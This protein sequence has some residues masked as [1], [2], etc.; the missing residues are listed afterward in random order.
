MALGGYDGSIR[1]DTKLNTKS[2]EASL[3]RLGGS[4]KK[5]SAAMGVAFGVTALIRL[6]KE[7]INVASDLEEVEN[8]VNVAFGSMKGK[9]EDFADTALEKF[10]MF[11][12][13]AKKTASTYMAMNKGMGLDGEKAADMAIAAAGRTGDIASFYNMKQ[14]EAD[15]LMKSIWT[16]E[17]ESLK[18]IGVVMTEVNL[19]QF[20]YQ[21]GINKTLSS[22]N[23]QE[24][25]MLRYQYV[26]EQTAL[27]QGDFER[28][29]DSWANQTRI[30]SGQLNTLKGILGQ[31]LIQALTPAVKMI[32]Q[33]TASLIKLAK[34]FSA[35]TAKL[36]GKQSVSQGASETSNGFESMASGADDYGKSIEK[37]KK[38]QDG[39]L[40]GIDEINN[41]PSPEDTAVSA[42]GALDTTGLEITPVDV[43]VEIGDNITI[44][45]KLEEIINKLKSIDLSP[46]KESLDNFFESVKKFSKPV[47]EGLEWFFD[48]VL[49]PLSKWTIE[50]AIPAFLDLLSA[51]LSVL[52]PILEAGQSVLQWL[53]EK[54]LQPIAEWTGEKIIEGLQWLTEKLEKLGGWL[55]EHQTALED[56]ILVLGSFAAVAAIVSGVVK[57]LDSGLT[58]AKIGGELAT[59]AVKGF[60]GALEFLCN[61]A[62][63]AV[64]AIGALVAIVVLLIKHW[65]EVKEVASKCW[66]WIVSVWEKAGDWFDKNVVEPLS[67]IW[68]KI[69]AVFAPAVEWFKLLFDNIWKTVSDVFYNIGVIASGCWEVIKAAWNIA[70]EWFRT[71]VIE[72]VSNFFS[73]MWDGLKTRAKEAWEGVKAAFSPVVDW[74]RNQFTAAWTAVK[75]VFSVGGKIFDGITQ[76]ITAAFKSVVNAIINGINKVVAIPFNGINSSLDKLRKTEIL[77]LTPFASLK[78]ISVPQIPRLATGAVIP[79]NGEFAAILGDQ[80]HGRNLE[81]PEGLIRQI[82]KEESGNSNLTIIIQYPDG[83]EKEVFSLK[84]IDRMNR[85]SGKILVPVGEG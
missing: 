40:A 59:L 15:T 31:G 8:V 45:P 75:N 46:A 53:W 67:K 20:A 41:M 60:I 34:S 78:R 71:T 9:V 22:M 84:K 73:N 7:S 3:G 42:G 82:V 70:S 19:Q 76:G 2:F 16:G 26:M 81:A 63:L 18:R 25:V 44:S 50:K 13:Q 61:P 30:L 83:R 68:E 11:E 52:T 55:S 35:I 28:T 6:G 43:P 10:G 72:P 49:F 51:S 1:I 39:F 69:K 58:L 27:A 74:F 5:L 79:P 85:Q 66:E 62:T 23:Q 37:A 56:F 4:L 57:I 29:A 36:F 21:K 77:G 33:M 64:V 24:K 14:E 65:D 54:F 17:T 48:N 80:K 12:L 32:N 47:G 38:K